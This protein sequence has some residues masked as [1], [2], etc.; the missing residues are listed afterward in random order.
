MNIL[1]IFNEDGWKI[2][3]IVMEIR[4]IIVYHLSKK[5]HQLS[6]LF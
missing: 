3:K 4:K 1:Y 2:I 6:Q 5:L